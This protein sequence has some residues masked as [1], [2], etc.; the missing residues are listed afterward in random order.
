MSLKWFRRNRNAREHTLHDVVRGD[1][2]GEGF[3]RKD[4][5]VPYDVEGEILDVLTRDVAA[6]AEV[7]QRATSQDEIDRGARTCAV[8]DVLGYVADAVF[9]RVTRGRREPDDVLHER[10]VDEDLVDFA[11]Q[12]PQTLGGHHGNDRRH[13]PGH[14]LDND[15]FVHPVG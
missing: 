12:L 4:D 6:T 8:A 14:P 13:A 7:G 9:G 10:R 11:L 3:E 5:A 1:V 2:L 15:E